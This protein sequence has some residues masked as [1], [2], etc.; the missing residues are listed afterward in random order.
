MTDSE[1]EQQRQVRA[2]EAGLRNARILSGRFAP[3]MDGGLAFSANSG[4]GNRSIAASCVI[5]R[6]I[7]RRLFSMRE[8]HSSLANTRAKP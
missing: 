1:G 7:G 4:P 2:Q 3:A 8:K 5:T 6:R